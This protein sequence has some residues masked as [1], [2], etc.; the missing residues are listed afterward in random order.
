MNFV[1]FSYNF[2]PKADAEAY[3]TTRFA[4]ALSDCGHKVTVVT[5]NWPS[6]V[7]S[8]TY[9]D[10][11]SHAVN[12]VRVPRQET[13]KKPVL[14]RVRYLTDDW[15]APNFA[16]CIAVLLEVL[17]REE[18]PILISRT[19]PIASLI[20]AW[21]C[22]NYAKKWIAHLSDPIPYWGG[23]IKRALMKIWC[24]RAFRDADGI[25]VTCENAIRF[26]KETYGVA[27]NE[28]KA[29]VTPHIGDPWL[30]SETEKRV[31]D[32]IPTLVHT[33]LFYAGRGAVP[34]LESLLR[35]QEK[36]L[37]V[38]FIQCGEVDP[39][40]DD[41]FSD[42]E[43]VVRI[44]DKSPITAASLI[45]NATV[46]F[47]SDVE[48]QSDYV[49]YI[50]SKFVYQLFTDCPM[51]VFTR[52]DSPMAKLCSEYPDS[53]LFWADSQEPLSLDNAIVLGI[54]SNADNFSR[55]A[56]RLRFCRQNVANCFTANTERLLA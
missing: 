46:S 19:H 38:R 56:I 24:R 28:A 23:V 52:K 8:K 4:S 18:S 1:I 16:R 54:S 21:H 32:S 48:P 40:I 44:D 30:C 6:E 37:K 45:E 33:G 9:N 12:I 17:K 26:Y 47:V 31:Q 29:F 14:A 13:K 34:L 3:C 51:V 10:L 22:R 39:S 27:F 20:V 2:L 5:M 49:P 25:S 35:L 7:S 43:N 41:V 42:L 53:G 36:G 11:V 55:D 15:E 50:P